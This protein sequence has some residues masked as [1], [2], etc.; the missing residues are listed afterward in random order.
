MS[1]LPLIV[2][3]GPGP[4]PASPAQAASVDAPDVEAKLPPPD[5]H[6]LREEIRSVS[7]RVGNGS[8]VLALDRPHLRA[9]D[10]YRVIRTRIVQDSRRPKLISVSSAGPGDG[11]TFSSINIAC[12]L[13]LR[14]EANVLLIDGDFRRST[15]A[16]C[17]GIPS[18]PGL[19]DVLSGGC[20]LQEAIVR[21]EQF[22]NLYVLPSGAGVANP[23]ELLDSRRW[24][25]LCASVREH[26]DF[27]IVDVPPVVAFA[28][29]ELIQATCD[30]V[31]VIIRPDH[32]DRTMFAKALSM[33]PKEKLL[34]AVVNCSSEWFLWKTHE[35][36]YYS[37][38][39]PRQKK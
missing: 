5:V 22:P 21:V 3:A 9:A 1:G 7:I 32:T 15:V 11:K 12:V 16:A 25:A 35:Y 23:V 14:D 17:L 30:G 4:E 10:Q 34:G 20:A 27:T 33:I 39:E 28:D 38:S 19:S 6:E 29:Y 13:S 26:F 36:Y 24:Q 2:N 18:Q 37:A 8:A 31:I